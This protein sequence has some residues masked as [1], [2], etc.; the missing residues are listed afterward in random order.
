M[1]QNFLLLAGPGGVGK[2]TTARHMA[3]HL[4]D[5]GLKAAVISFAGPLYRLTSQAIRV[6]EEWLRS[7]KEVPIVEE[8]PIGAVRGRTPRQCLQKIGESFRHNFGGSFWVDQWL[9]A[10]RASGAN[11]VIAD[12][13]RHGDEYA[14]GKVVEL[15]RKG[16]D[17]A[18]DHPSAMRPSPDA[19]WRRCDIGDDPPAKVAYRIICW[20][21]AAELLGLP[22]GALP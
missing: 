9:L 16:V 11:W 5:L 14:L 15:V 2:S 8:S 18:G 13:A 6:P 20:L 3:A 17:Y 22:E 12:D 21:D 10:A 4:D 19:V 7:H 1:N